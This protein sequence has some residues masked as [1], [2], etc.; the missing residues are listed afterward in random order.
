[1]IGKTIFHFRITEKLG[2][3]GMGIVYKAEDTKLR[4]TVAL[5]FLPRAI[6]AHEPERARFLQEAQAASALNHPHVCTIH[7]ICEIDGQQFI[8]MEFVDGETLLARIE[9]HPLKVNDALGYAIQIGEALEEAHSSGIVH[10]DIKPANIMVN[11]KNQIK[12]MDFGLAK[13]KGSLKLTRTSSTVGTLAYMAPEQIEGREVDGRSDI[14]S[15]GVVLY[16]MLT[17]RRPFGGETEAAVMHSILGAEAEPI[18]KHLPES[19]SEVVHVLNRALEKDPEDRYQTVHDMLI[20]LRRAKKETSRVSRRLL[21]TQNVEQPMPAAPAGEQPPPGAP[22]TAAVA[23]REISKPRMSR[24]LALWGALAV[25]SLAVAA[26]LV[27]GPLVSSKRVPTL[28]P[29]MT[30]RTLEVPFTTIGTPGLSRD[31]NWVAFAA[32][33]AEEKGSIYFMN[34]SKGAPTRLTPELADLNLADI[35]PDNSEVLYDSPAQG[36]QWGI[37]V[38]PSS[39]GT[40]RRIAESG[41]SPRWRPDGQRIGYIRLGRTSVPSSTG[42]RE[43]WSVNPDGSESRLEFV[44]SLTDINQDWWSYAWSPDGQSVAWLRA[45]PGHSE[46]IIHDLGSGQE[47]Q[48]TSFGMPIDYLKWGSNG[49]VF[50]A[51]SK[52][53]NTNIWMIPAKGGEAVQVTRG[54]GPDMAVSVSA[55]CR[56]LIYKESRQI[57]NIWIADMDGRNA[58]Q[59]TFGN[60]WMSRATFAPDNRIAFEITSDD[61]YQSGS[62]IFTIRDDGSERAQITTGSGWHSSPQWSRDGKYLSYVVRGIDEPSESSRVYITEASNPGTPK[63]IGRG[64]SASWLDAETLILTE[65]GSARP[66][67][68]S[69]RSPQPVSVGRDSVI[70]VPLPDGKYTLVRDLRSSAGGYWLKE[71]GEPQGRAPRQL[72]SAEYVGSAGTASSRRYLL[73]LEPSGD[74]WR[75]SI[76]E[77]RRERLPDLFKNL[78]PAYG[79]I[80]TSRDDKQ[81]VYLK[82]R[83]DCRLLV[84]DNLFK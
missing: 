8:V 70:E 19:T 35:S 40:G 16:E 66:V 45:L 61:E 7:D 4:R 25:A 55:D 82:Q 5:K 39:G 67:Q 23:G 34:V 20:D 71:D 21:A 49:Q 75:M 76:P 31:G 6:D 2:E 84:I 38:V 42:K 48:L 26:V 81:A 28:N 74:L 78:N 27:F 59:L 77:G 56:R 52:G 12:V 72:L 24:R 15:F 46:I 53:G 68:Y 79:Q 22:G 18:Q 43:F 30:I 54:S 64:A 32:W 3:G 41:V 65:A 9:H 37:Y 69:I 57:S 83:S 13:L 73:Y 44:D 10:R 17:G 29:A 63:L 50:F 14:F 80:R 1:M 62:Q 11:T 36:D 60:Q 47:R 58:R 51:S 33:D